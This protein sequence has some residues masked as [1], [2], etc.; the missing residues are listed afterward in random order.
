MYNVED[1][2]TLFKKNLVADLSQL[3]SEGFEF[4]FL[5]YYNA[6]DTTNSR[7]FRFWYPVISVMSV[8]VYEPLSYV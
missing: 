2:A 7:L 4:G 8:Y 6:E 5:S 1:T 3:L